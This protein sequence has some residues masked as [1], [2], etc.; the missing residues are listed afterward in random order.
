LVAATA[1]GDELGSGDA[2][3]EG[4]S[5]GTAVGDGCG[6]G[7]AVDVAHACMEP[8]ETRSAKATLIV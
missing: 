1:E 6:V 5:V 7:T 8:A 3:G 2:I 4:Y